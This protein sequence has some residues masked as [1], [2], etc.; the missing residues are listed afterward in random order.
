MTGRPKRECSDRESGLRKPLLFIVCALLLIIAPTGL[1][2][3]RAEAL[4]EALRDSD[5]QVRRQAEI[6]LMRI[7][8]EARPAL[9]RATRRDDPAVASAS[10]SLLLSLPWYHPSDTPQVKRLLAEYGASDVP[11]RI[12]IASGL[13]NAPGGAA[14]LLRLVQEDPSEDVCWKIVTSFSYIRQIRIMEQ[15]RA[16][17]PPDTR[18]AALVLAGR[19]WFW[20]DRRRALGFLERAVEAESIPRTYDDGELDFAFDSLCEAAVHAGRYDRAAELRRI[21]ALRIGRT[22]DSYPSPIYQLFR[23]HGQ[24]GPLKGFEDDIRDHAEI[25]GHPQVLYCLAQ[26]YRRHGADLEAMACEQTAL[27]ASLTPESRDRVV[28]FL[29][30]SGWIP[31]ARRESWASLAGD[32]PEMV[33]ARINA[34][35]RLTTLA[36]F[37]EN[38]ALAVEHL[39]AAAV[40]IRQAQ[41]GL[42]R[43]RP[44]RSPVPF[45]INDVL[46]EIE[47]RK[48]RLARAKNDPAAA[49]THLD[50]FIPLMGRDENEL[51]FDAY[52]L[53]TELGRGA[54]AESLFS[55]AYDGSRKRFNADRDNPIQMNELAWLCARC[56]QR[57]T[58]ALDLANRA[59]A[60]EPENAAF[61]D[62]L[63]EVHF[64]L[65][66][67]AEAVRLETR[68]LELE[69]GDAFMTKQLER[70][71]SGARE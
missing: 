70:F 1:A 55:D 54:D 9:I 24:Y 56:G 13:V 27:A 7:G 10:A 52:P 48:A 65:G 19:G 59:V 51:V 66:N 2:E 68:A 30:T 26:A 53:L 20:K 38:D 8:A 40:L 18:P 42:V 5:P 71:K 16:L 37:D 46:A 64:R 36:R 41:G 57:L 32:D 29:Q 11:G 35:L 44:N 28:I 22:R 23:L 6:E 63:A 69:P 3:Q 15:I 61:L 14:A 31:Q 45:D 12:E 21:Q 39:S 17:D 58:E 4:I 34:R 43:N 67:A 49:Q 47:L 50:Q 25:L 33:V 62:T 60:A